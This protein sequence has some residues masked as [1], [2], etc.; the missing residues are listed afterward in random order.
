MS[1]LKSCKYCG[2]IHAV[3]FL[4]DAA[5]KRKKESTEITRLRTCRRWD[6]TRSKTYE[7]DH[8]LCRVCLEQGQIQNKDLEAHHIVPLVENP[9]LAYELDNTI[10]LCQ[11][12]HTAA[13]A[14][15]IPRETLIA[16]VQS[17]TC[18]A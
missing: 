7:R 18:P 3:D 14:G 11:G 13:D 12:H 5:P 4:C 8:F 9:D 16:L 2:R 10:T 6:K 15:K 1:R 17:D